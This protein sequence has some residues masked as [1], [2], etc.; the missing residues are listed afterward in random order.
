MKNQLNAN[1][2]SLK[3]HGIIAVLDILGTQAVGKPKNNSF[4]FLFLL[5][6]LSVK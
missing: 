3:R 1:R 2:Q 6:M 4:N 5:K